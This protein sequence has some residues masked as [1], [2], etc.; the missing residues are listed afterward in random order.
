MRKGIA[1]PVEMIVIV[2]IAVLVL[3][4]IAAFFTG[5]VVGPFSQ[6]ELTNAFN[7]GCDIY[8]SVESCSGLLS[9]VIITGYTKGQSSNTVVSNP[10]AISLSSTPPAV[11]LDDV[12]KM[13]GLN[14]ANDGKSDCAKVCGCL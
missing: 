5:G 12:C 3:V 4:V 6:I 11:T 2:A 8:R 13:K 1:L 9:G 14:T 7:K 10:A